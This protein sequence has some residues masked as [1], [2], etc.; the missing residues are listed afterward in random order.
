[1]RYRVICAIDG[2]IVLVL[3]VDLYELGL[4]PKIHG[5]VKATARSRGFDT[6]TAY[7]IKT[8]IQNY[9]EQ[10]GLVL[11]GRVASFNN[12]DLM[13]LPSFSSKVHVYRQYETTCKDSSSRCVSETYFRR[14]WR[15]LLPHIVVQRPR[16]DLCAEC[17]HNL[18]SL[19]QLR[20][21]DDDVKQSML[22]RSVDHLTEVTR[23]RS[24]YQKDVAVAKD[25]LAGEPSLSMGLLSSHDPNSQDV[26][27]H[28]SFDYA[29]QMH[30]PH[31]SQQVGP[32]YFLTP[33]KVALFGVACEPASK[34]VLY[35]IPENA[36]VDKGSNS[37]VSFLHHFF[38]NY[39]YGEKSVH[40][41]AD[42]CT[43]QNK[44]R[45]MMAYL[46]WRVLCGLHTKIT[47]SFLPVGHTIWTWVLVFSKDTCE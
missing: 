5:N 47:L 23:E 25:S 1:M 19:G 12:A 8:F 31:D 15:N 13:I 22:Q 38:E 46:C 30:I 34:M 16:T 29:Q 9:A 14:I 27:S 43:G 28:Y 26:I 7:C 44:N 35:A 11:P 21:F 41:R 20:T 4:E 45:F 6:D 17:H 36:V 37:V 10:F 32:L 2:V 33:Y 24:L 3:I 42:N 39:A 40:L 18:T